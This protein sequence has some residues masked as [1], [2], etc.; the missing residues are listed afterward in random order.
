MERRTIE[1]S[2][3]SLWRIAIFS[4]FAAVIY[5][6]HQ[7][8]LGLFLAIVISSGF[9]GIIDVIE[10]RLR[11]PRGLGV[12]LV[13]LTAILGAALIFYEIIPFIIVQLNTIALTTGKSST[14]ATGGLGLLLSLRTSQSASS[15]INKISTQIFSGNDRWAFFRERS[16]ISGSWFR[17][18]Q[19]RSICA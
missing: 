5:L 18:L 7:V 17:S 3:T 10:R 8:V 14:S 9:E 4:A 13:F 6:G 11:I 12:V 15:F 16:A 19:A 2:W 1:I